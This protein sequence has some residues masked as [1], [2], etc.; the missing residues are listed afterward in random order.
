MNLYM[1]G[2]LILRR[3]FVEHGIP[4]EAR[5]VALKA[6]R[7]AGRILR[8]N[9]GRAYWIKEKSR[10]DLLTE[11]DIMAEE[12]V[13]RII[14]EAFPGHAILAEESGHDKSPG[15]YMWVIDPLDGTTNYSINNPFFNV[16]V[17]LTCRNET[18]LGVTLA[19]M[20]GEL[21]HAVKDQGAFL[22]PV[23][24]GKPVPIR[25]SLE[26]DISRLLLSFCNGKSMEDK[27]EIGEIFSRLK[28]LAGD[29]DRYKSGALELAFVASGRFGAYL[30]NSQMSWDSS[31]GALLVREAGGRVTDFEGKPWDINSQDMLATNGLIH[32]QVLGIIK[33]IRKS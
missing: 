28:P 18:V 22:E 4:R 6:A 33:E 14:R 25:V 26:K 10:G 11:I 23:G 31:A 17:S 27:V 2:K 5:E 32:E 12:A 21:F 30:A 1:A 20:T 3:I 7:E 13:I 15:D 19:P 9:F 24:G 8:D 29:L 16:S